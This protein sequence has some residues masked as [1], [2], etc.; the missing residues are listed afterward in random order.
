MSALPLMSLTL[1]VIYAILGQYLNGNK[2]VYNNSDAGALELL[3]TAATC[4]WHA[5]FYRAIL[6]NVVNECFK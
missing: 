3:N 2:C 1:N 5:L 6:Y 4:P